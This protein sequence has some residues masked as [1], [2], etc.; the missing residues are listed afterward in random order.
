MGSFNVVGTMSNLSISPGDKVVFFALTP[1]HPE[2]TEYYTVKN[3]TLLVSNSGASLFFYPRF[4]PI[5]GYYNDYGSICNIEHDDNIQYIEEYFEISIDEFMAQITRNKYGSEEVKCID[6]EK[7]QELYELTGMFELH[8]VYKDMVKFAKQENSALKRLSIDRETLA[9]M[10]FKHAS[11]PTGDPRFHL[12][13]EH[14]DIADYAVFC[15]KNY[16]KFINIK[17]GKFEH[18][19]S[20]QKIMNFFA[21]VQ[22]NSIEKLK[23]RCVYSFDVERAIGAA[24]EIQKLEAEYGENAW[25]Y[26]KK[27]PENYCWQLRE[28]EK[29]NYVVERANESMWGMEDAFV[30]LLNFN[31]AMHSTNNFYYPAMLGEQFGNHLASKALCE[32]SLRFIEQKLAGEQEDK[33]TV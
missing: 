11:K 13:Y 4:L 12:Y 8:S 14:P 28:W 21:D 16:S 25:L 27:K 18:L 17:T 19:Y 1:T 7:T 31:S 23:G 32:S 22:F 5:V 29:L 20:P 30:D 6:D 10:G 9:L 3:S 2:F 24:L 33:E 15:D 26:V